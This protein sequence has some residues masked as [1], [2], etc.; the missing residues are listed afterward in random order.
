MKCNIGPVE[1][2]DIAA[3][4]LPIEVQLNG[5]QSGVKLL[6]FPSK[7]PPRGG[8]MSMPVTIEALGLVAQKLEEAANLLRNH[9]DEVRSAILRLSGTEPGIPDPVYLPPEERRAFVAQT[10]E[11]LGISADELLMV[12][13]LVTG[14]V[15]NS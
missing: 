1:S 11:P 9:P 12:H 7:K 15:V 4:E 14:Y 13:R 5:S 2:R 3:R 10:A 6:G 8:W